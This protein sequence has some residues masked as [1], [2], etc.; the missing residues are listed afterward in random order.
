MHGGDDLIAG[1]NKAWSTR[2][3]FQDAKLSHGEVEG[4]APNG[5]AVAFGVNHQLIGQGNQASRLCFRFSRPGASK[6]ALDSGHQNAR[7]E[8]FRDVIIRPKFNARDDIRFFTLGRH[9]NDGK[10]FGLFVA[11]QSSADFQAVKIGEHQIKQHAVRHAAGNF[12]DAR[13]PR[14]HHGRLKAIAIH[15]HA[16][17]L[18]NL[19]FVFNNEDLL[20]HVHGIAS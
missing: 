12:I 20:L 5:D 11:T 9:H 10:L 13:F 14:V 19:R 3:V 4:L 8:G 16:D 7:A 17:Q 18:R 15:V 1:S 2:E 6:H